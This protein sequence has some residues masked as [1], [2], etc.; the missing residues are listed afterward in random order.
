M[1]FNF[2]AGVVVTAFALAA[3]PFAGIAQEEEPGM[4]DSGTS[5]DESTV[6]VCENT[7]DGILA[8]VAKRGE[9]TS[10]P[11]ITWQST[12]FGSNYTPDARCSIVS[13]KLTNAVA[14]NGGSLANLNLTHGRVN[15]QTVICW[16]QGRARCNAG[17]ML[18]TLRPANAKKAPAI[19]QQLQDFALGTV[20]VPAVPETTPQRYANLESML[21]LPLRLQSGSSRPTNR[22]ANRPTNRPS[23]GW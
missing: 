19:V 1:K 14:S 7:A 16:V 18:F 13:E 17:N 12:Y 9:Y 11:L 8:T 10:S 4:E 22:P 15:N 6:F 5:A 23:G 3:V 21:R 20:E 2:V